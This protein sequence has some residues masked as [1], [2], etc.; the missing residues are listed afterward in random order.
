M[1][2]KKNYDEHNYDA[3]FFLDVMLNETEEC[4]IFVDVEG[5]IVELSHAY[6]KFLGVNRED[7]I[8]KVV[9]D[10]IENT[11]LPEVITTRVPE[12]A[13]THKI[14]G[15]NMIANRIPIIRNGKV[16]GAFGRVLFRNVEEL[17]KLYKQIGDMT[18]ELNFYERSFAKS[19]SS[20]YGAD[21][22]VGNSPAMGELK[23]TIKHIAHS[24]SNV[25]ILGESG[26]GKELVAHAIHS[27]YHGDKK[28]FVCVNC[29]AIPSELLESELFGYEEG[30]FTG[31]KK[32]GK[33]GMFQAADGGT[34]FLDEIG[35]M[36]LQMQAK[37]L[38]VLQDK[39][40]QKV[41]SNESKPVN[42]R[43]IAAT[44]RN[45]EEMVQE[46]KFRDDLYFR[47]NVISVNIPPLR[48]RVE[49]I[50]ILVGVLIHKVSG[51]PYMDAKGISPEAMEYI[52][53]YNW[54]GNVREL[55][56]VIEHASNFVGEDGIIQVSHLPRVITGFE[57]HSEIKTLKQIV[58]EVE[59]ETL[60]NALHNNNGSRVKAAK[61]L[62]ISR[63]SLYEKM[64]K[65]NIAV[66]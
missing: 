3:N 52:K 1:N 62:G 34:L 46:G 60:V 21:D 24:R 30:S 39:K 54:P 59:R 17:D 25:L 33:I 2:N 58:D 5:K 48:E 10:V 57:K 44:N 19:N 18:Q 32:G 27:E 12:I 65:H 53:K 16:E 45:L 47:L 7:V 9:T 40:V 42:V 29:A 50:P 43:I 66:G 11:R 38:R 4:I 8:G 56:N 41:G 6:A 13:Q 36:P 51:N 64:E 22:I 20:K 14:K 61:A 28:P 55:E 37:L 31:A 15:K 26:T 35:E 23:K 49:D 63:T